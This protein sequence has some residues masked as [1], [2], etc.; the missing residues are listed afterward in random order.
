[1]G[2]RLKSWTRRLIIL[3]LGAGLAIALST[4][5]SHSS[6]SFS[7]FRG[8]SLPENAIYPPLNEPQEVRLDYMAQSLPP[9]PPLQPHPL[10]P[11]LEKW[12]D[13]AQSG[14]YFDQVK[15]VNVGYLV[16]SSFPVKVFIEPLTIEE[17]RYPFTTKRAEDWIVAVSQAVAEWNPYLPLQIITQVEGADI[18]LRRSPPPLRLD[19]ANPAQPGTG[20]RPTLPLGRARSAETRFELYIQQE[21]SGTRRLKH[22]FTIYLRPDQVFSYVQA[23]ARHELG[24]ALGIWGHSPQETDALYFSQV[25]DPPPIS[26]RDINTLKRV[27]EQPTRI[28]WALPQ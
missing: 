21:S 27:Y 6:R 20:G 15:P 12:Q 26:T 23:A 28:G 16:W 11:S 2:F 18:T 8:F 24:H 5:F 17:T 9:L 13:P 4:A 10:P 22:R 7:P 14:D 25:K 1:M 3:L 19:P